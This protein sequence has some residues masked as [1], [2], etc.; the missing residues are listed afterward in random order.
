[1]DSGLRT[2]L[3]CSLKL[4]RRNIVACRINSSVCIKFEVSRGFIRGKFPHRLFTDFSFMID[5]R[6][7]INF[8]QGDKISFT[9]T[10]AILNLLKS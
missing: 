4:V 8:S 1:M 5:F 6:F 3:S 2:P 7:V 10:S 9:R